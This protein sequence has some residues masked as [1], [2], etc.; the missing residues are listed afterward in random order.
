MKPAKSV[1]SVLV[2][3]LLMLTAACGGSDDGTA[4]GAAGSAS[5]SAGEMTTLKTA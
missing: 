3:G 1:G 4:A 5:G 2:A